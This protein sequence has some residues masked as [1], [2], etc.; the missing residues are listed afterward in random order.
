MLVSPNAEKKSSKLPDC[1]PIQLGF[2]NIEEEIERAK[3]LDSLTVFILLSNLTYISSRFFVRF[4]SVLEVTRPEW[5][6]KRRRYVL[7]VDKRLNGQY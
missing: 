4:F 2:V 3:R 1:L 6:N 7:T 5:S